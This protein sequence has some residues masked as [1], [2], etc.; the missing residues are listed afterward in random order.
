MKEG[1]LTRAEDHHF[2][3]MSHVLNPKKK[4][5]KKVGKKSNRSKG[6][7]DSDDILGSKNK[8]DNSSFL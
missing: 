1:R 5:K 7:S 3:G 2:R 4:D 6:A 8:L